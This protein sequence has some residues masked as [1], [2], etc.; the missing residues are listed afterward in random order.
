MGNGKLGIT[1]GAAAGCTTPHAMNGDRVPH[2]MQVVHW[3]L[4]PQPGQ[5]PW[6]SKMSNLVWQAEHIQ[7]VPMGGAVPQDGQATPGRG[8]AF[9]RCRNAKPCLNPLNALKPAKA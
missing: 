9:S 6:C 5:T 8:I 2:F 7:N 3:Y 4:C 1:T